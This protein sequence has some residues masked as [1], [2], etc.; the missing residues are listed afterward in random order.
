MTATRGSVAE[1]IQTAQA[2]GATFASKIGQRLAGEDWAA[3]RMDLQEHGNAIL[4]KVLTPEECVRIAEMYPDSDTF[5]SRIVMASHGFGRGEYKYFKYPLPDIISS[6]RVSLFPH[7]SKIA[8]DWNGMLKQEGT[9]PSRHADYIAQCHEAGQ[10]RP[11][12]LLL[13]YGADDF[14]A[15]H[16][17]LYGD[18]YFPIQAAVLLAQ[19][20]KDFEGGEFVMSDSGAE[21]AQ[22]EVVPLEQG[23]AVLFA[24]RERPVPGKRGWRRAAT[25]HGV[26]RVRSGHR[27]T[28]GIIFH[29]AR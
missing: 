8:N 20:G 26:S 19:P 3:V 6:L 25:R 11:T 21:G 15:L 24:V 12:P 13:Q 17:D 27:H 29:D 10:T 5:R 9:Y 28:V 14:N 22:L 18:M 23:D 2:E 1:V 7:L 4:R 16:Q